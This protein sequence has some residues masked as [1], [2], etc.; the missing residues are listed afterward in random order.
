MNKI[1]R[2][3]LAELYEELASIKERLETVKEEEEE[4]LENIPENL[5]GSERYEKA[6]DGF[7][8]MM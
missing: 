2:K 4:Y 3:T 8:S 5:Q 6:E 1:R 7:F